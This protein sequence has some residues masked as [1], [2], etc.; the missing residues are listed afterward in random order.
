MENLS[1]AAAIAGETSQAYQ[2]IVTMSMAT[3]R[4]IGIGAYLV[5]LGQRV[6]QVPYRL[7]CDVADQKCK[8]VP[9][10]KF[11]HHPNWGVRTEQAAGQRSLH[12]KYTAG[13]CADHVSQRCFSQD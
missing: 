8:V 7:M 13:R 3:A 2:E 9:G 10:R 12:F 5:R 1:A 11:C 4:A 6:V